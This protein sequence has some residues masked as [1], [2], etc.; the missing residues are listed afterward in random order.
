MLSLVRKVSLNKNIRN[1]VIV[2]VIK[3]IL[4]DDKIY[5]GVYKAFNNIDGKH[6]L[7]EIYHLDSLFGGSADWDYNKASVIKRLA[8][9]NIDYGT[10]YIAKLYDVDI[11]D[12]VKI[13][14]ELPHQRLNEVLSSGKT[15]PQQR[16]KWI[17]QLCLI[18]DHLLVNGMLYT[19]LKT[20]TFRLSRTGDILITKFYMEYLKSIIKIKDYNIAP[21]RLFEDNKHK[22]LPVFESY[23]ETYKKSDIYYHM[24]MLWDYGILCLAILYER[25]DFFIHNEK[26]IQ[27]TG[28]N[29]GYFNEEFSKRRHLFEDDLTCRNSI[30]I[31]VLMENPS[32]DNFRRKVIVPA[33]NNH[34]VDTFAK[35]I[36]EN[37]INLDQTK[38]TDF[39]NFLNKH[40]DS[41]NFKIRK[42][43][44]KPVPKKLNDQ[45]LVVYNMDDIMNRKYNTRLARRISDD[46]FSIS[47]YLD[48][49]FIIQNAYQ[50]IQK[51]KTIKHFIAACYWII[52]CTV[53]G[54]KVKFEKLMSNLRLKLAD[55]PIIKKYIVDIMKENNG[56]VL[57]DSLY[58]Y[59]TNP[60]E[61]YLYLSYHISEYNDPATFGSKMERKGKSL[62]QEVYSKE[63][64]LV[65]MDLKETGYK[66]VTKLGEGSQGAVYKVNKE[67]E[68][69]AC[70]T[71]PYRIREDNI[72]IGNGAGGMDEIAF[73]HILKHPYLVHIQDFYPGKIMFFLISELADSTLENVITTLTADQKVKYIY[74]IATA[75]DYLRQNNIVHCDLKHDNILIRNDTAKVADFGLAKSLEFSNSQRCTTIIYQS[76]ESVGKSMYQDLNY[77]G[78]IVKYL[79]EQPFEQRML[80]NDLWTF[81]MVFID[82]LYGKAYIFEEAPKESHSYKYNHYYHI[83]KLAQY[84]NQKTI[85]DIIVDYFGEPDQQLKQLFL[86]ISS[87]IDINPI[88]RS[89]HSLKSFIESS[90]FADR[91]Y[92]YIVPEK[93]SYVSERKTYQQLN[94]GKL[95]TSDYKELI[96]WVSGTFDNIKYIADSDV[97]S[98]SRKGVK[99]GFLIILIDFIYQ[100]VSSYASDYQM[101]KIFA[102]SSMWILYSIILY[103]REELLFEIMYYLDDNIDLLKEMH[104]MIFKILLKSKCD[105]LYDSVYYY[106]D[107]KTEYY[108]KALRLMEDPEIY[109]SFKDFKET[110]E[111]IKNT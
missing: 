52:E 42:P 43:F 85:S 82:I 6:Y 77:Y 2:E 14:S 74:Q 72:F 89:E 4:N 5:K 29:Y 86:L 61:A 57:L 99:Y 49:D 64:E 69:Y 73:N 19:K 24:M 26:E 103:E 62:K 63:I 25:E 30:I 23:I 12:D 28:S 81:G 91:G 107:L 46:K 37:F 36:F 10:K 8:F 75:C 70:K 94:N 53:G 18:F 38:R 54:K 100:N 60:K 109:L 87:F 88:K 51:A 84:Y 1:L 35:V 45:G 78:D 3:E 66:V 32:F 98:R 101:M 11:D 96:K 15:S 65:N 59:T 56:V 7:F 16:K 39:K 41:I 79:P 47:Y 27:I 34:D 48:Q 106:L 55:W 83:D 97:S 20:K 90:F 17:Y 9:L 95:T 68:L 67:N 105:V 111:Y 50:F 108:I 40:S 110:A 22:N 92:K 71:Y 31:D 44:K 93:I 13:I 21:E 33:V 102:A 58:F 104:K 76:P 80:T